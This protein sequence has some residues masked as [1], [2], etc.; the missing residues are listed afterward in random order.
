M[1]T[2]SSR[3]DRHMLRPDSKRVVSGKWWGKFS[4]CATDN[5]SKATLCE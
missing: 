2:G 1:L 5:E 4:V 3:H